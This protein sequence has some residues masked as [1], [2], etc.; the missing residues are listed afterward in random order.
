MFEDKRFSTVVPAVMS[1]DIAGSWQD[2]GDTAG[3]RG[4][5]TSGSL[6]WR[7]RPAGLSILASVSRSS[8]APGMR[9]E[10]AMTTFCEE[11]QIPRRTFYAPRVRPPWAGQESVAHHLQPV[12]VPAGLEGEVLVSHTRPAPGAI[13]VRDGRPRDTRRERQGPTDAVSHQLARMS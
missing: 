12:T 5:D 8:S 9:H 10:G 1:H 11:R 7:P 4:D 2:I 3:V 6:S 13:H